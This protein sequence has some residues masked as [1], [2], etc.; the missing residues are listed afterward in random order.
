MDIKWILDEEGNAIN[1]SKASFIGI[2]RALNKYKVYATFVE[3]NRTEV[4]L[5]YFDN[6]AL[7]KEAVKSLKELLNGESSD[8]PKLGYAFTWL[9][10][11]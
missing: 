7:A 3:D 5:R 11:K 8:E 9:A 1:V 10:P 4:T 6:L 2:K